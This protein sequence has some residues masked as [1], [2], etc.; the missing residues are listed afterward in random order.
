[1]AGYSWGLSDAQAGL[2]G[3]NY[4]MGDL[5]LAGD[6]YRESL[7]QAWSLRFPMYV[8]SALLGLAAVSAACDYAEEGGR[9]LGGAEG[10]AASL[11]APMFPR[12]RP[13]HERG[14]SVLRAALGEERLAATRADGWMMRIEQAVA[15][16]NAVAEAVA[17]QAPD[18]QG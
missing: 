3:V 13:I 11:G 16:A 8:A 9:L 14:L 2:A 12:D 6:R 15:E 5:A 10:L 7:E 1:M 17:R 18:E 4:C